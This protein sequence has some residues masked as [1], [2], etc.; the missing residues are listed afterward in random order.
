MKDRAALGLVEDAEAKG[1]C[2]F[3]ASYYKCFSEVI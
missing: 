2:A 3:S 1:R